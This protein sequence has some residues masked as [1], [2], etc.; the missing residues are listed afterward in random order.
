MFGGGGKPIGGVATAPMVAMALD[1]T[2]YSN[3]PLILN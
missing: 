3:L 2:N 1:K